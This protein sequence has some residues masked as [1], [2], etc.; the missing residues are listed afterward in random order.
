[1]PNAS[2]RRP[3]YALSMAVQESRD[4]NGKRHPG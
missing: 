1:M 2:P 3:H 4:T